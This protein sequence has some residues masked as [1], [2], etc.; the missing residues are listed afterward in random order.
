MTRAFRQ[1]LN[2]HYTLMDKY[3]DLHNT[4]HKGMEGAPPASAGPSTSHLLGLPILP[5]DPQSLADGAVLRFSKKDGMF[6]FS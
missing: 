3:T 6:R 5:S 1:L 2:Q 4:V